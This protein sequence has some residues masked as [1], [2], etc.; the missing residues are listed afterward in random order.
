[1]LQPKISYYEEFIGKASHTGNIA[2]RPSYRNQVVWYDD[3]TGKAIDSTYDYTFASANSGT[4][5]ITVPHCLTLT[6]GGADDDDCEFAMGIDFYPQYNCAIE[7]RIRCDDIDKVAWNVGF[8]D[9]QSE[10]SADVIAFT[11]SGAT[12]TSNASD[13]AV[14]MYDPDAD[15]DYVYAASCKGD[16]DGT[17]LS[18]A[19]TPTDSKWYT[20]RVEFRYDPVNT[21][22]DA[23]FYC[24]TSGEEINPQADFVGMEIDAATYNTA[25]CPYIAS[26]NHGEDAANTVD[27]DYIKVWS[28][29]Q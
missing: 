12:L 9:Q 4:A 8:S 7:A 26:I 6:T 29:R 22:A 24:N 17:V 13:G 14:F 18:T 25:L 19:S 5:T 11:Y 23:I 27:I 3:F 16:A 28:D 15:T 2:G 10:T 1:M 20:V 21:R